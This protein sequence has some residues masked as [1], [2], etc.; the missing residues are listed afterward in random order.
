M[1]YGFERLSLESGRLGENLDS[2]DRSKHVEYSNL[3]GSEDVKMYESQ[4][5]AAH[6][7]RGRLM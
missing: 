3:F 6:S 1:K 7:D 2:R 4:V 5:L